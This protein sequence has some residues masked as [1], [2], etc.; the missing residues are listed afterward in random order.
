[1]EPLIII[2]A[3]YASSRFP[4]KPL[5][6]IAGE[7]LL[8]RVWQRCAPVLGSERVVVATDSDEIRAHC[9]EH[10][11]RWVMTP[12]TC[13]TG[14]DR[15]AAAAETLQADLY[16]NVQGDEPLVDPADIQRIIDAAHD[17]PDT[18]LIAYCAIDEEVDYYS[19][20]VP[21]VVFRSDSRLLYM[22]RAPIPG[23]K[24]DRFS[25]AWK[26][27]CIYAFPPAALRTY[28]AQTTKT[29]L[30]D[31]EDIEILRFL[32]LGYEVKMIPVSQSSIAVDTP[33]DVAR[34]ERALEEANG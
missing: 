14:T 32:E 28:A 5:A 29:P 21:K 22:S 17:H 33:E 10:G 23:N 3:R 2:P 26:Q 18:V 31:E 8:Y 16:I 34:V 25:R 27:V 9:E 6:P 19:R 4:G 20:T 30:E 24:D 11:M 7:S 13:P 1:M 15:L 12:D